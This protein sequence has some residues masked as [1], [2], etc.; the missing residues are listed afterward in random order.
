MSVLYSWQ[1]LPARYSAW[2]SYVRN[3]VME[4]IVVLASFDV[5][6]PEAVIDVARKL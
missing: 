3:S 1:N 4:V 5:A 6:H 2:L